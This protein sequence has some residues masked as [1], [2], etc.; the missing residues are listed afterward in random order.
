VAHTLSIVAD[1]PRQ[2]DVLCP[3][4]WSELYIRE[5]L[6]LAGDEPT[7]IVECSTRRCGF[8]EVF[9]GSLIEFFSM[10]NTEVGESLSIVCR[11]PEDQDRPQPVER[12]RLG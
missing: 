10:L 1:D 11:D 2:L 4:C 7:T 3:E 6:R 5:S 9:P 8:R 12:I